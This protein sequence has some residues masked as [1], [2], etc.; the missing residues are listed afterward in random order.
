[1]QLFLQKTT[2]GK[3]CLKAIIVKGYFTVWVKSLG[4]DKQYRYIIYDYDTVK[5]LLLKIWYCINSQVIMTQV[6]LKGLLALY[7]CILTKIIQTICPFM[8]K[9]RPGWAMKF[10]F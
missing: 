5:I 2:H 9:I 1:M 4:Y 10:K 3:R 6:K 7:I 8:H